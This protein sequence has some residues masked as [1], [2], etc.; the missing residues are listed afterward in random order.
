MDSTGIICR[1]VRVPE[2]F[3][4]IYMLIL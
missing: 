4:I 3:V 1:Q 2:L